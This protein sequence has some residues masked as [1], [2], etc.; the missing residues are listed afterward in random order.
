MTE[1]QTGTTETP[2]APAV[3]Q[4]VSAII[5][6]FTGWDEMAIEQM[7]RRSF[8][9]MGESTLSLRSVDFVVRRRAGAADKDAYRACMAMTYGELIQRYQGEPEPE[10]VV[11]EEDSPGEA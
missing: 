6:S 8:A 1:D 9:R 10:A 4:D 5:N 11:G 3:Q 2:E 7:F